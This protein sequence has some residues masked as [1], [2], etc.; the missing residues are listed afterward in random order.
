MKLN[1][2]YINKRDSTKRVKI[3]R[4]DEK[5]FTIETLDKTFKKTFRTKIQK[6]GFLTYTWQ[7]SKQGPPRKYY[8]LTEEGLKMAQFLKKETL[9]LLESIYLIL[10]NVKIHQQI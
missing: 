6:E 10:H 1:E 4:L 8:T 2:I 5:S 3:I 7:E 9:E